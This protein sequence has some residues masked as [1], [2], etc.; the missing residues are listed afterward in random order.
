MSIYIHTYIQVTSISGKC[1]FMPVVFR[2][3]SRCPCRC[4]GQCHCECP[5][6]ETAVSVIVT[7]LDAM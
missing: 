2:S 7:A 3:F 4:A 6:P 5:C 1:M